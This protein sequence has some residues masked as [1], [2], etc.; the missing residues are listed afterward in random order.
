MP[1]THEAYITDNA[2]FSTTC[3][4]NS[5][6]RDTGGSALSES[7]CRV[8]FELCHVSTSITY[9]KGLGACAFSISSS[10]LEG[11]ESRNDARGLAASLKA[12]PLCL[13]CAAPASGAE[14]VKRSGC[15]SVCGS[16]NDAVSL[17]PHS[18]PRNPAKNTR[19][20]PRCECFT[21]FSSSPLNYGFN[22][23]EGK[24][25]ARG[26]VTTVFIYIPF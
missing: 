18:Y 25:E 5:P 26:N 16:G 15:F 10:G 4:R 7:S 19:R 13:L 6:V 14:S 22:E 1:K 23:R 11:A 8:P 21:A 9:F 17:P 12:A 20:R 2:A 24:E 3:Q